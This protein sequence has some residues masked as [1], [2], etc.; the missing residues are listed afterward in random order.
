MICTKL[1][2]EGREKIRG[3]DEHGP[4]LPS[5]GPS[6]DNLVI[7]AADVEGN[8]RLDT[9]SPDLKRVVTGIAQGAVSGATT[10]AE[11]LK[12]RVVGGKT[13][14]YP[15]MN[16]AFITFDRQIAAHLAVQVLAHHEPYRMS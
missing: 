7:S 9:S 4:V 6:T 13:G 2:E 16:S 11:V 14:E 15:P 8:P 5:L 3:D 12:A 10:T 1:L